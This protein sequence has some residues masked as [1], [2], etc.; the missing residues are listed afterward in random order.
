MYFITEKNFNHFPKCFFHILAPIEN[1]LSLRTLLPLKC[2]Q[3]VVV[4]L[5]CALIPLGLQMGKGTC[6]LSLVNHIPSMLCKYPQI[7]VS[8]HLIIMN[9]ILHSQIPYLSPAIIP[10]L[11]GENQ[12]LAL[13]HLPL[14]WPFQHTCRSSSKTFTFISLKCFCHSSLPSRLSYSCSSSYVFI[15]DNYN[16]SSISISFNPLSNPHCLPSKLRGMRD[17]PWLH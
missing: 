8:W 17:I 4:V 5:S 11:S 1:Q 9:I 3:V 13:C 6:S 14:W 7:W 10:P 12:L 15:V 2:A 16:P